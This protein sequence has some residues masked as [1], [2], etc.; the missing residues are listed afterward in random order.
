[1]HTIYQI[2][3]KG[4]I[5]GEYLDIHK[6]CGPIHELYVNIYMIIQSRKCSLAYPNRWCGAQVS[7][8]SM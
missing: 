4:N 8:E 1:M 3:G 7:N 2:S 5:L 6:R